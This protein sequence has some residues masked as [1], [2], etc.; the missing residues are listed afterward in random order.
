[1]DSADSQTLWCRD[2]TPPCRRQPDEPAGA[3]S[4]PRWARLSAA[5]RPQREG[6]ADHRGPCRAGSHPARRDDAG[7]GRVRDLC[8]A[9]GGRADARLHGDLPVGDHRIEREGARPRPRRR[10]LHQQAVPGGRSP[11]A[12]ADAPRAARP[13]DAASPAQRGAPA[14]AAGGAGA[15]ARGARSR[16]GC[17]A[18]QQHGRRAPAGRHQDGGCVGRTAAHQRPARQRPR[19]GGPRRPPP[20]VAQLARHHLRQLPRHRV[21]ALALRRRDARR[22]GRAGEVAPR[23]WRHALPRGNPAPAHRRT[24]D[25]HAASARADR[26]A[27][28]LAGGARCACHRVHHA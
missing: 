6:L 22:I 7:H 18:R 24:A 9:Q 17:A 23:A 13:A 3:L 28:C 4:D 8:P 1:M 20:V 14:R 25:R 19:S 5:R 15:A 21:G 11:R 27:A 2:A 12:R 16:R 26:R 10:R